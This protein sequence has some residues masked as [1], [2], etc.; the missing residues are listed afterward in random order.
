[1]NLE[2]GEIIC[3]CEE[4][5]REEILAAIRRGDHS[6]SAIKR[7]TRA[8]MGLCQGRTCCR[9]IARIL[10][11]ELGVGVGDIETGSFRPPVGLLS[12][13]TLAANAEFPGRDHKHAPADR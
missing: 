12:L 6:L 1:M 13:G 3:R 5:T 10:A 7:R 11:A 4:I 9:L 8:G 2:E